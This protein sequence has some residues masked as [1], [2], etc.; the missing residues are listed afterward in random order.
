VLI[1]KVD[2]DI[3]VIVGSLGEKIFQKGVYAY[4][5]S[6]QK[7]LE[8]R[9]KRHLKKD[10]TK[11]WHIDYLLQNKNVKIIGILHKQAHK[12]EECNVAIQISKQGI[13][14]KNFGCSD[15][16]CKSHLFQITN[17][18]VLHESMTM[19]EFNHN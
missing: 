6:A 18:E 14:V 4:V 16:H 1:I 11:F 12:I 7:N 8:Q 15:C 2:Q 17:I 13:A 9:I 19:R 3:K 10:K 5:G